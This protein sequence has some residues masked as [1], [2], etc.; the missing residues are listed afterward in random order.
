KDGK[1]A[2]LNDVKE[3]VKALLKEHQDEL[4]RLNDKI[5]E[6]VDKINSNSDELRWQRELEKL[7]PIIREM[8]DKIFGKTV[9]FYATHEQEYRREI[10]ELLF[11]IKKK[12]PYENIEIL[13]KLSGNAKKIIINRIV[14]SN[15]IQEVTSWKFKYYNA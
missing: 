1:D 8:G 2:N 11:E 3:I 6:L 7:R 13:E 10:Q 5:K 4:T 12:L 14:D 9:N 15:T